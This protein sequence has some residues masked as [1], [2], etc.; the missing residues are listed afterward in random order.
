MLR[1][2]RGQRAGAAPTAVG[3]PIAA[4]PPA[5]TPA[6]SWWVRAP[7]ALWNWLPLVNRLLTLSALVLVGAVALRIVLWRPPA[8]PTAPAA[9]A[10]GEAAG[11]PATEEPAVDVAVITQRNLFQGPPA[12]TTTPA[13]VPPTVPAQELVGRLQLTGV[14]AGAV[15]QAVILDTQGE[16][17]Y[18]V[19]VGERLEGGV[20]V[21]EITAGKVVL[22]S[23]GQLIELTL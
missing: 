4:K 8:V 5:S 2:I 15:P 22:E 18:F 10:A 20:T 11:V 1:L 13:A 9:V 23:G 19:R 7:T 21:K 17:T 12:G 14:I 6:G 16:K 3:A